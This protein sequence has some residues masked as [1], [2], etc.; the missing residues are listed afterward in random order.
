[1]GCSL[2]KYLSIHGIPV[3]GYYDRDTQ[4]A[5]E[6]AQFTGTA[7]YDTQEALIADSEVLFIT[8]PDGLIAG[9]FDGIRS[10]SIRG[11]Y[12]CHCSG[13]I[14]SEDAFAGIAETG[15]YGYSLHPLFAVSDRFETY[16]ELQDAF[17]TLEGD[18]EGLEG[19]MRMLRDAGMKVRTIDPGAKTKYHL[20]AVFSSNLMLALIG[21]GVRLLEECGFPKEDSLAALTPLIRGNVEH[22]LR[23]GPSKA[24]TGPVERGDTA[25]LK[26]HIGILGEEDRQLYRLLSAKL[27]PLAKGKNPE[28]D[29]SEIEDFLKDE[30]GKE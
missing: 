11:K 21:E 25:T 26:R 4:M 6:A 19:I 20:A 8:V 10:L 18:P 17:F 15:A 12:I 28:R 24:L 29:Y 9:V 22:A 23:A 14:S 27:I 5:K 16:R 7:V 2:G 13:S 30:A 3:T 1:M